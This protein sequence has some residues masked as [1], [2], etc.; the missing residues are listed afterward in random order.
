[1]N[2]ISKNKPDNSH[3]VADAHDSKNYFHCSE[4]IHQHYLQQNLVVVFILIVHYF[5]VLTFFLWLL[6]EPSFSDGMAKFLNVKVSHVCQRKSYALNKEQKPYVSYSWYDPD[7]WKDSNGIIHEFSIN[8]PPH[9]LLQVS[10]GPI[11]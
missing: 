4:Y 7:E 9:N 5:G 11:V 6:V 1:M 8:V 10:D 3:E 2:K